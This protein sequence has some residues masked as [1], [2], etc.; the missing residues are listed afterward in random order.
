MEKV[1]LKPGTL[2]AP[3]A[4]VMVTC[5]QGEEKNIITI[6]EKEITKPKL[7]VNGK[8]ISSVYLRINERKKYTGRK[9]CR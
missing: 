4:A 3:T 9:F 8:S 5:G 7:I 1:S 6:R 2:L